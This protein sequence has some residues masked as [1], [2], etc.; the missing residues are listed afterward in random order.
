M[1]LSKLHNEACTKT[2][3]SSIDCLVGCLQKG[4]VAEIYGDFDLLLQISYIATAS[5][6]CRGGAILGIVQED[7]LN[8]DLYAVR[9]ALRAM[10]CSE[11]GLLIS[12]A[13]RI[14]DAVDMIREAIE[15]PQ[16]NLIIFDPY[17]NAPNL[18]RDYTKLTPL[19]AAIR[20]AAVKGKRV[21]LFNRITK[22]GKFLPEG[23][24][25]HHHSATIIVKVERN[26]RRSYR[27]TLIKHPTK[28]QASVSGSLR[29]LYG[30][31]TSWEGQFLLS[32]WL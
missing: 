12:R 10:E 32:E 6:H 15:L 18:P 14:E 13:F 30:V 1:L 22:F 8:Y 27:V 28:P 31:E 21:V 2:G 7:L 20:S 9:T 19:T 3:I 23:G 11:E 16:D 29:E 25:L 24:N 17:A 5:F 4:I 26:G